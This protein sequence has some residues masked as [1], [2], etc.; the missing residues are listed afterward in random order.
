MES[1]S[2]LNNSNVAFANSFET[3]FL[4]LNV[5][6]PVCLIYEH[7]LRLHCAVAAAAAAAIDSHLK[8]FAS[9]GPRGPR[10]KLFSITLLI[11]FFVSTNRVECLDFVLLLFV[12]NVT[13]T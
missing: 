2:N 5:A 9:T 10:S 8:T 13:L 3:L 11:D 7:F 12:P 4:H 1:S 6:C